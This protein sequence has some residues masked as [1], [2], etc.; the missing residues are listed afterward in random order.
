MSRDRD[1]RNAIQAALVA[2]GAF[3][4]DNHGAAAVWIWG[5][6]EDYGTHFNQAAAAIVPMSSRQEDLWDAA[7]AGGLVV[8]SR[9][10]I[11]LLYRSQD[12]QLR[13]EGAELLLDTTAD[14]LNGQNFASYTIPATS[15]PLGNFV[16][17]QT[18][19]IIQ[20]DWQPV[21]VPERRINAI[22]SYQ[23]IVPNW[24]GYDTT[25]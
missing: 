24:D 7:P 14:A 5:L 8:T 21:T 2:T 16:F 12:P 9:V 20:W 15:Q 6:P 4:V 13:D 25:P 11:V 22:F 3:D 1:V 18:A 10:Q 23:Y 19:R 17:P